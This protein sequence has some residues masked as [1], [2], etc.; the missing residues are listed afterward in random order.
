MRRK[1]QLL[2]SFASVCTL[3]WSTQESLH[4]QTKNL[5]MKGESQESALTSSDWVVIKNKEEKTNATNPISWSWGTEISS[6]YEGR[7]QYEQQKSKLEEPQYVKQINNFRNSS[8]MRQSR[9]MLIQTVSEQTVRIDHLIDATTRNDKETF[10][11]Q[12]T[13]FKE[14]HTNY[15]TLLREYWIT[16][17][18]QYRAPEI[19]ALEHV[20]K[21]YKQQ[22]AQVEFQGKTF[23]IEINKAKNQLRNRMEE[24]QDVIEQAKIALTNWFHMLAAGK[25]DQDYINELDEDLRAAE[26]KQEEMIEAFNTFLTQHDA[27]QENGTSSTIRQESSRISSALTPDSFKVEWNNLL[28]RP[29]Y[30]INNEEVPKKTYDERKSEVKERRM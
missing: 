20:L 11:T 30:F 8:Q 18:R 2:I 28:R 4:A 16:F 24:Y 6:L 13:S 23:D 21:D 3:Y 7:I 29:Q 9:E 14:S 10:D 27:L 12:L 25:I 5:S 22:L 26:S 15:R 1:I 17:A 19:L